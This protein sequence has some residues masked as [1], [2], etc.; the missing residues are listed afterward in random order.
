MILRLENIHTYYGQI[1]VL[2]G[3]SLRLS[4][5]EIVCLIGANGAGKSTTLLTISGV[6][7]ASMGKIFFRQEEI[8][9][10]KPEEIVKE[11]ISQVPEGRRIFPGLTV[12]E[13]LKMGAY[14]RKDKEISRDMDH[15]FAIFPILKDRG[16]Q[17]GGTLSGGEQQ[18]L[19]IARA[20]MSRPKLLLLDEPSL[21]LAPLFVEKIF[22]IIRQINKKGVTILLVEQNAQMALEVADYGYV[23]E[24]GRIVLESKS[25]ELLKNERVKKAYLGES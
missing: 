4:E 3:I 13:N 19:A 16:G 25:G 10:L 24:T 2:K 12:L 11:G 20:L 8:Q 14:I 17:L 22:E 21:G 6:T 9:Q 15:L 7:P 23:L 5:G 1:E 18:M